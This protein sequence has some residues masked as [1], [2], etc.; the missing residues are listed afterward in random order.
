MTGFDVAVV[1]TAARHAAAIRA[2]EQGGGHVVA[3]LDWAAVTDLSRYAGTIPVLAIEAEGTDP[4]TL[5]VALPGIAALVATA[6][7]H[8]VVTFD[9]DQIDLVGGALMQHGIEL[10][11]R[12]SL[13]QQVAAIAVAGHLSRGS[14]LS[15]RLREEESERQ[16]G[17]NEEIARLAAIIVDFSDRE[18]GSD[19][20]GRGGVGDRHVSFGFQ[21]PVSA[22]DAAA[23]RQALRARRLRDSFFHAGLFEDPAWDMLLDLYAAHLERVQVSVSSLCIAAA[24]A[25][26]TALRWMGRMTEEGLLQ[27]QPDP[28]D[29]RRVFIALAPRGLAG[30][31][32]YAAALRRAGL[33]F[34]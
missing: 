6:G 27:R 8:A 24:V 5:E 14:G 13:G 17:M 32:G 31:E 4:A 20:G 34:A 33:P 9:E 23:V 12:P 15:D 11:C 21:P 7:L 1:A 29:R 19:G 26:T 3:S 18:R 25:P 2:A 22:V 28:T 16:R 10:L 30:M